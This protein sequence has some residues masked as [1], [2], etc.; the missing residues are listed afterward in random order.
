MKNIKNYFAIIIMIFVFN[1]CLAPLVSYSNSSKVLSLK[2]YDEQRKEVKFENE[3]YK[4][5]A[6][7][8]ISKSF[9]LSSDN[10]ENYGF[11]SVEHIK[12][13]D[14]CEWKGL[15]EGFYIEKIKR[16]FDNS[17]VNLIK[18]T[19][20]GQYIFSEYEV[21]GVQNVSLIEL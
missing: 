14:R 13:K 10:V 9:L 3:K 4:T 16:I 15:A 19:E 17:E 5:S 18:R 7:Y 12:I 21:V 20:L 2:L 1:G 11:L 8:C 6:G